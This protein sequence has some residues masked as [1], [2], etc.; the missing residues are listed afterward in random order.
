MRGNNSNELFKLKGH[1][2]LVKLFFYRPAELEIKWTYTKSWSCCISSIC[3]QCF[4]IC[5]NKEEQQRAKYLEDFWR[6]FMRTLLHFNDIYH[7][8]W[9][10]FPH[11]KAHRVIR[12][13]VAFWENYRLSGAPFDVE[14]TVKRFFYTSQNVFFPL[15]RCLTVRPP[16][17]QFRIH[18]SKCCSRP[19][20]AVLIHFS[21][22]ER[23]KRIS[24][25]LFWI[26]QPLSPALTFPPLVFQTPP[27]WSTCLRSFTSR[28]SCRASSAARW[29]PTRLWRRWSGRKTATLSG[30]R[31]SV[32]LAATLGKVP[33]FPHFQFSDNRN[34]HIF[35]HGG[36]PGW[37]CSLL[38]YDA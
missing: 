16:P 30:S 34:L 25:E 1:M 13:F 6:H 23:N 32:G 2:W 19:R 38:T 5:S 18:Q 31:R 20:V 22:P 36:R 24:N 21:L 7:F 4:K 8:K 35:T 14:N 11:C 28:G 26:R 37:H 15:T 10:Y 3:F 27:E 33:A 29:T 9:P 12:C 17:S